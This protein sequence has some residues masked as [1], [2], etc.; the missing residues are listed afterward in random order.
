MGCG[1]WGVGC[2]YALLPTLLSYGTGVLV[3]VGGMGVLVAVR[4]IGV[5]VLVGVGGTGVAV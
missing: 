2:I 3:A 4:G 5:A 1:E